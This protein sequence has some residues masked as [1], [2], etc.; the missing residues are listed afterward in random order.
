MS[1]IWVVKYQV[2]QYD[3]NM[4]RKLWQFGSYREVSI[5]FK[6]KEGAMEFFKNEVAGQEWFDPTT[7]RVDEVPLR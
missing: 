6:T 5:A 1:S 2:P 7:C 3:V 4:T